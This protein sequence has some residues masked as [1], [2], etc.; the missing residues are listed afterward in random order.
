LR[1][2]NGLAGEEKELN[3][4]DNT[5]ILVVDSSFQSVSLSSICLRFILAHG[6]ISMRAQIDA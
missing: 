2:D 1:R 3:Q 4:H 5:I 6:E